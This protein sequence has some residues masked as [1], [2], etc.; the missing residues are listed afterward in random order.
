MW[1]LAYGN[2]FYEL[3]G[4][5]DQIQHLVQRS[6][7]K[8]YGTICEHAQLKHT[9]AAHAEPIPIPP[10]AAS[11]WLHANMT[12]Q[13]SRCLTTMHACMHGCMHGCKHGC[14]MVAYICIAMCRNANAKLYAMS[15][16]AKCKWSNPC[17]GCNFVLNF[18]NHRCS[19][20]TSEHSEYIW[21]TLEP[22]VLHA[23]S[24]LCLYSCTCSL[25]SHPIA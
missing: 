14:M 21:Q 20:S 17:I 9:M 18:F 2:F 5:H 24:Q 7:V 25:Q 1:G 12:S 6:D 22:P 15:A 8:L 13:F 16:L 19:P 10:P 23:L 11:Q 4:L 3:H